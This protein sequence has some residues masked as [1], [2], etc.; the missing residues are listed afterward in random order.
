MDEEF[1][2]NMFFIVSDFSEQLSDVHR[3]HAG[4]LVH[5]VDGFKHKYRQIK[6]DTRW[7]RRSSLVKIFFGFSGVHLHP[8]AALWKILGNLGWTVLDR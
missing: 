3:Q 7:A 5:L 2:T 8:V 1:Y 6:K 4:Q